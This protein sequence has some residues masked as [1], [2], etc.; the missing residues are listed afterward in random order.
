[1]LTVLSD[2][3][4][5]AE[6]IEDYKGLLWNRPWLALVFTAML[7]SLAGIPLTAG[8][9]G[10]FYIAAAGIGSGLWLL[11][12]MLV[13]NSVIGLF[14]YLRV[15]VMMFRPADT[16]E[17]AETLHPAF[18]IIGG[19]TLAVLTLLLVWFGVYPDY[20]AEIIRGMGMALK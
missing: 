4:R 15:V 18:Y 1:V 10:K 11:V 9:I 17:T 19:S 7:L 5:D 16:R 6:K 13:I 8:F 3:V 20:L 12:I 14:Y 2:P